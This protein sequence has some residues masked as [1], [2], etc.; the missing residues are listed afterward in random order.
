VTTNDETKSLRV[1]R[2][3]VAA[4]DAQWAQETDQ[5]KQMISAPGAPKISINRAGK[6]QLPDGS[7]LGDQIRVVVVEFISSNKY[8]TGVYNPQ[9]PEPPVCFAFGK[10]LSDME[11]SAN[12]PEPQHDRCQGCDKNEFGSAL[13]GRG[14]ACKNTRELAVILEEDLEAEEPSIYQLSV[15]PT[16]I[17][18]FDGF[19]AQC[20][21]VIAGPPI[22]AI[23]TVKAVPQGTYT[24]LQ[25]TDA[26]NN[27]EYGYHAQ[28]IDQA[29]ELLSREPDLSNYVPSDQ[30]KTRQPPARR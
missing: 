1:S 10:V 2:T 20:V 11:P 4:L 13:T 27:P 21:R 17:R 19:V 28:Y 25:F 16:A 9:N 18:S 26:D 3:D 22:K 30:K 12:A 14:K 24:T 23:V 15:P 5:I 29:R 6:F 7:E 8:Y